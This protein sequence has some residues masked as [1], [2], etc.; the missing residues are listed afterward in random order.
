[1]LKVRLIPILYLMN[2]LIVRSETF[3]EFKV[4]GNP[5]AELERYNEWD[6]DEVVY[7][8]ITREGDHDFR[9]SD[10]AY[11]GVTDRYDLVRRVASQAFMPLTFG[12][13][14]KTLDG[15]TAL[16]K[17]GADKVLI[18]SAAYRDPD[19]IRA[20]ARKHGKQAIVCGID[21][22]SDGSVWI[23][24]GR[25][26]I[27][28]NLHHYA[29]HLQDLGAGEILL[30]SIDRDGTGEGYDLASL[31]TVCEAVS[32]PV[33]VAGGV[34]SFSDFRD[35]LAAG[36]S[37]VAAGNLF[38]HTERSYAR[39]KGYLQRNGVAVRVDTERNSLTQ[40]RNSMT[41]VS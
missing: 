41:L 38:H 19:L 30:T 11:Q 40:L 14:V 15:V 36:A 1:M 27:V 13:H 18:T 10:H 21:H 35:G 37:A 17:N 4:I 6:A 29:R 26:R 20:A 33:V 8:D 5:I 24:Q 3:S 34:G 31:R 7:I 39:A 12:G 25:T 16:L 9:R 23:D 22:K 2:G 28:E 32:V